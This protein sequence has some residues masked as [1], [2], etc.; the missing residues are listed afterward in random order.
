MKLSTSL[1]AIKKITSNTPRSL[2]VEDDL[3]KAAQLILD[4]EGVINPIVVRRNGLQ[5]Y[6]VVDGDFEYYA[7][8]RAREIDPR[9]GEMIGVFIIEPE[10]EENL[11]KQVELFRKQKDEASEKINLTSEDLEKFLNNLESRLDKLAK[12][13]L[14]ES[15]TK[16]KLENENKELRK[17][18]NDKVEPLEFFKKLSVDKIAA[19][20]RNTGLQPKRANRIAALVIDEREK[21]QFQSLQDVIERVKIPHGK[22]MQKGIGEKKMLEIIENLY[23][24]D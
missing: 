15:T 22:K 5:S 12:Q 3:E 8:A 19:K 17:K 10:N 13:L 24:D 23:L 16:V 2:F 4:S 1:V 18:L 7:A 6:E 21:K 14:E 9:K 20:L 11:T